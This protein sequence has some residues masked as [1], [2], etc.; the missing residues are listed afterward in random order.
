MMETEEDAKTILTEKIT[1]IWTSVLGVTN[2]DASSDFFEMGGDSLKMMNMIL[3][4]EAL[5]GCQLTPLVI[6]QNTNLGDFCSA[7]GV[8]GHHEEQPSEGI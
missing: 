7:L 6:L 8:L 2:L 4:V 3:A 5:T 1:A